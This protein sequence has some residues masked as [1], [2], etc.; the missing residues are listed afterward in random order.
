VSLCGG[1]NWRISLQPEGR[2]DNDPLIKDVIG[3]DLQLRH[4]I[5]KMGVLS[6]SRKVTIKRKRQI[7][8]HVDG[9]GFENRLHCQIIMYCNKVLVLGEAS[10]S[11]IR[12]YGIKTRT[13]EAQNSCDLFCRL[14]L[15][16]VIGSSLLR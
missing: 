6:M 3:Y 16:E 11:G 9:T 1:R 2:N 8:R 14:R 10:Y 12:N 7:F 5:Y 15:R 13:R 4:N